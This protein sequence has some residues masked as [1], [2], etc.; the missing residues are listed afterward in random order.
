[1]RSL[2]EAR[3]RETRSDGKLEAGLRQ[4]AFLLGSLRGQQIDAAL[5]A[6][7]AQGGL[8]LSLQ[9]LLS[10]DSFSDM[11][12]R[13]GLYSALLLVIKA[14]SGCDHTI[15]LLLLPVVCLDSS[16]RDTEE[17]EGASLNDLVGHLQ[18]MAAPTLRMGHALLQAPDRG[19]HRHHHA[20]QPYA[21]AAMAD[22]GEEAAVRQTAMAME[23]RDCCQW[24]EEKIRS[25]QAL[26]PEMLDRAALPEPD[27]SAA[28][29]A[30]VHERV[31]VEPRRAYEDLLGAQRVVEAPLAHDHYFR[32]RAPEGKV[33]S[34]RWLRR[35]TQ[36]LADLQSSLPV[37]FESSILLAFDP[38]RLPLLRAVIFPGHDTPY[39]LGAFA[40]DIY[41]PS[42]YPEVP[43][44]FSFLTTGGGRVRMNP[45]LYQDG[46]V[47]QPLHCHGAP[48][49]ALDSTRPCP[50]VC[51][52]LLGTWSG[53]SWQ[54]GV[55]TLLQVLVSIQS[56]I[57][58]PDP[59]FNEPGRESL[60]GGA[61]T[62]RD[63]DQYNQRC[64]WNTLHLA[65][66]PALQQPGC[67]P[68]QP[69]RGSI[70]AHFCLKRNALLDIVR[71]W[72]AEAGSQ[73][74]DTLHGLLRLE[75]ASTLEAQP[76]PAGLP[77]VVQKGQ[78]KGTATPQR[79]QNA[80]PLTLRQAMQQ[81]V[82]RI[83]Q[84]T[85]DNCQRTKLC[86]GTNGPS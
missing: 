30:V 7:L 46:K 86:C 15:P 25:W 10:N 44:K 65:I 19:S 26:H 51:L 43:P 16:L 57:F 2:A 64:R 24:V 72:A 20:P 48:G 84:A 45:N 63:N 37:C 56:M 74:V 60:N 52:S 78:S 28:A 35:V 75:S 58:V 14:L 54:P 83:A 49:P 32:D 21:T 38:N 67:G 77:Q 29:A 70:A 68:L 69:F 11:V 59:Y 39:A 73:P 47:G 82:E 9:R 18:Q 17:G 62:R 66:L 13:S 1:M 85:E 8:A 42:D 27:P 61:Q 23:M 22:D 55:S 41:L 36:E 12:L 34:G 6:L 5:F 81:L 79:P 31:A 53:P 71:R 50:Q 4:L 76:Q 80:K 3:A 40:F 33:L